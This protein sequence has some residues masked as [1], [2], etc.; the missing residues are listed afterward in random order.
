MAFIRFLRGSR[1][2]FIAASG[3][4]FIVV[5]TFVALRWARGDRPT[6]G[7]KGATITGTGLLVATSDPKGAQVFLDDKLTTATDDTLN[8]P[9]G[10][11]RVEVKKDGFASW[12]KTLVI[13]A[14]LVT[15]TN[16]RLFPSVP[17]LTPLTYSG[18]S[19]PVPSPD[20]QKIVYKVNS[21]TSDAKNGLWVLDLSDRNLPI[22]H[23]SEPKQISR[24]TSNYNFLDAQLVWVPDSSQILAY[25][26]DGS[27]IK[28]AVFLNANSLTD[29][30]AFRDVSSRLPVLLSQWHADLD[31]KDQE[32]LKKLPEFM[33]E[34]ALSSV[35]AYFSPDE[36]RLLY[37]PKE[38]VTVPEHLIPDLPSESTQQED[39]DIKVNTLYVYDV[40]EDRNYKVG[41]ATEQGEPT[42]T[43]AIKK[44]ISRSKVGAKIAAKKEP[45]THSYWEN[46]LAEAPE[47]AVT[48]TKINEVLPPVPNELVIQFLN[49]LRD[50]YSPMWK[51]DLQWFPTSAHLLERQNESIGIMEYDGTNNV[52][53]YDGPFNESFVYPW[54]NGNKLVILTKLNDSSPTNLYSIG[55][56]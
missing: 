25:W 40:K 6:F 7:K 35:F 55:L 34:V 12:K 42:P 9:P 38:E 56:K 44:T 1:K 29:P 23:A 15:Q 54:P 31:L 28:A 45:I 53:I 13:A 30:E 8:L 39:R 10:S 24:N 22:A 49:L 32:K 33:R 36:L 47:T 52:T 27:T 18:A 21:A 37:R 5:G 14:E 16:T 20:G 3:V 41:D 51:E 4:I 19:Q 11:Y 26:A 46:R 48:V 43:P 17:N 50:R 2:L